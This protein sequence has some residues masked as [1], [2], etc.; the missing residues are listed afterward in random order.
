VIVANETPYVIECGDGVARQ[1]VV[2]GVSLEK[3]RHIFVTHHHSDHNADYGNLIW[4]AGAAGLRTRIDA[5]GPPPL[6]KMTELFLE[7]NVITMADADGVWRVAE[8][9]IR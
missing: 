8:Y 3:L 5:W 9:S 2:A 1:L 4:L 6:Q 7:M